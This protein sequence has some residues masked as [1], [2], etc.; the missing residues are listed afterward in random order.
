MGDEMDDLPSRWM[1]PWTAIILAEMITRRCFSNTFGQITRLAMPVSSSMVMNMTPFAEPGICRTSTRPAVSGQRPSR[2]LAFL[3]LT[4]LG[5][6]TLSTA[7]QSER[8][9]ESRLGT[10]RSQIQGNP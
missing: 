6:S 4:Q 8:E 9:R 5:P 1:R 10:F 3:R 2:A 7:L